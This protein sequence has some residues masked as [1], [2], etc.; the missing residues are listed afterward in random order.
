MNLTIEKIIAITF[1]LLL[2]M[3]T[4][5]SYF[6]FIHE[7]PP[8]VFTN[9]PFPVE[10]LTYRKGE[11]IVRTA[12]FCKYTNSSV[13]LLPRLEGEV[14]YTY[15]PLNV[16]GSPEGCETR[17]FSD[18]KIPHYVEPGEY[19]LTGVVEY[20]VNPLAKRSVRW[21]TESFLVVE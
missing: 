2:I 5:T 1:S 13:T 10:K 6:A 7:N 9:L 20:Q 11:S 8:I 14:V 17:V 19:K 3:L 18:L 15:A 21:E 16:A 4:I 12:M